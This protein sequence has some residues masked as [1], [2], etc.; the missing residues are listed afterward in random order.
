M[1]ALILVGG[2]G[3]RLR[4]LTLSVPKP[5]VDF[6][7]KPMILHQ[8]EAL[9]AIG[10]TEVVLAI[11]YQPEVMM[12]FLK[13]FESKLGIKIT[14]SRETEPLGTAG[15][16]ALARDKLI[17]ESGDP[18]FVLNS[19]VICEYPLE[20][21]IKFHKAHG[22]EASIMV[23][24]VDEPSKYGVVVMEE[25]TGKVEKFVEKP[26]IFVGN[27]INAGIYLLNPSVLDRIQLR[28][29]SIEKEVFPKIAAEQKLFAMVLP[30][31][32]MDIGQPRDYIT[33][34][35]L[36]LDALRKNTSSKL[37]SGSHILGNVLVH[38]TAVIGEGCLIGPDVAIGPGCVVEAGVRLALY[39]NA[40]SS[41]QKTRMHI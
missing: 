36:Y 14:C 7:N 35:R 13:D 41:Y 30:G 32:W 22:G 24:K 11:N 16:L 10:V 5:L 39:C 20:Q 18:F 8:I 4:P 33:G 31:F 28:P 2:F 27:K 3:T 19:D 1:K 12:S 34:L 6:A 38:E 9:K 29:T 15:P 40:W 37:S 21:M 26:K 25:A 23:T 17:D